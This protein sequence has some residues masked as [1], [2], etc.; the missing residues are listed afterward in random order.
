MSTTT[1]SGPRAPG[2]TAMSAGRGSGADPDPS[3][4]VGEVAPGFEPVVEERAALL[5][6]TPVHA[7]QPAVHLRGERV[8]DLAG[9]PGIDRDSLLA[10]HSS[11]KGTAFL[12][13]ALLLADGT[14]D[15][16]REVPPP[17][18]RLR[19][20]EE[21]RG[22]PAGPVPPSCRRHRGGGRLHHGGTGR[23]PDRRRAGRCPSPLVSGRLHLRLPRPAHRAP[24]GEVVRR[25]SGTTPRELYE[26]RIRAPGPGLPTGPARRTRPPFP[27]AAPAPAR[28]G[29]PGRHRRPRARDGRRR[30]RRHGVQRERAVPLEPLPRERVIRAS[31]PSSVGAVA[32]ARGPAGRYAAAVDGLDGRPPLPGRI[33]VP[34][35]AR[36]QVMGHDAVVGGYRAHGPGFMVGPRLPGADSFGHD[37]AGG[38]MAFADPR[39]GPALD[40]ARRTLPRPAGAGPDAKRLARV[41][42]RRALASEAAAEGAAPRGRG[43]VR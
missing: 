33:G 27:G 22:E 1:G 43:S 30:P 31:G 28:P 9:G 14:L 2:N 24:A 11:A 21:G 17:V 26:E 29:A 20:R 38:S 12:V 25:A 18:A 41:A 5:R 3:V 32:S 8:V 10:V 7:A 42:R 19:R 34:R 39:S 40:C 4:P 16:D 6:E 13:V 15:A 37:G 36:P 35:V 23:G